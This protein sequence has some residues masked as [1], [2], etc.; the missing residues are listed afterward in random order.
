MNHGEDM[1]LAFV[2]DEHIELLE[3]FELPEAQAQFTALPEELMNVSEGQYRIVILVNQE[4]VGFFLLHTTNRVC[5]Y[6]TNPKAMLLTA[7]SVDYKQQ[8]KGYAKQ[9]MLELETFVTS[10][11]ENI[12]EVVLAVN[13]KNL[14][15]QNLYQSVGFKDTGRRKVGKIGEQLILDLTI[16]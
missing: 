5:E 2:K 14:P 13:H 8:G 7:L 12:D 1:Q 4:P 6:T 15:A 11:F 3:K 10:T 9:A 16:E